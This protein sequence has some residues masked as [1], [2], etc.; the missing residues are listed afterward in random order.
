MKR[1]YL[2]TVL[3]MGGVFASHLACSSS[4]SPTGSGGNTATPTPGGSTS[5]P[6]VTPVPAIAGQSYKNAIFTADEPMALTFDPATGNLYIAEGNGVSQTGIVEVYNE[7]P[8][9][10]TYVTSF[11]VTNLTAGTNNPVLSGIAWNAKYGDVWVADNANNDVYAIGGPSDTPGKVW[12][13]LAGGGNSF[14]YP[15]ALASDSTGDVFVA[16]TFNYFVEEFNASEATALV[17]E[18]GYTYLFDGL[19]VAADVYNDIWMSDNDLN[20]SGEQGIIAW[21]AGVT[22]DTSFGVFFY[23]TAASSGL[24]FAPTLLGIGTDPSYNVYGADTTNFTVDEWD[25]FG[26]PLGV[27]GGFGYPTDVKISPYTGDMCVADATN[28]AVYIY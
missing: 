15:W 6:T 25:Q 5:T 22:T 27:D 16:D 28:Y 14:N 11:P 23:N 10:P 21:A 4:S 13:D 9:P 26:D 20:G 8:N 24:P 17:T 3:I 19:G 12:T 2:L 18:W 7:V 1:L